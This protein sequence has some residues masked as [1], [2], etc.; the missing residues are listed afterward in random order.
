MK[1]ITRATNAVAVTKTIPQWICYLNNAV[2]NGISG[3]AGP[4][5]PQGPQ[6]VP[7][8]QGNQGVQGIQG[9]EGIQGPAGQTG[10]TGSQGP[11]GL[12]GVP[13]PTGPQGPTGA[14]GP[15]G[16]T[17][18]TPTLP[19]ESFEGSDEV[20]KTTAGQ[21]VTFGSTWSSGN[22]A[23]PINTITEV[24]PTTFRIP[25]GSFIMTMTARVA[26]TQNLE[27]TLQGVDGTFSIPQGGFLQYTTP[28]TVPTL[29]TSTF[30][31]NNL[32]GNID[33]EFVVSEPTTSFYFEFV[34]L[35]II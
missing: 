31:I 5:G 9:Q 23:Q 19:L 27:I 22:P 1:N 33:L 10:A 15:Q 4:V 12:Q 21:N 6:G 20:N 25:N 14:T 35:R 29:L 18:A 32:S 13:G 26:A 16:P 3:P 24:N 11:Q 30:I 17:G 7:G 34:I 8:P 2:Q 28:G